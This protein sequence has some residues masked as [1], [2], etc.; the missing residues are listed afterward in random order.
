MQR[1]ISLLFAV[2]LGLFPLAQIAKGQSTDI[3]G[4]VIQ[5]RRH[6]HENPE[7]SFKE[8][9]TADYVEQKLKSFGNIETKR[10]TATSVIGILKGGKPG[11]TVAFRADMDALPI[12]EETGLSFASKVKNVSHAC[13]HD[14]HTAMLLGTAA[15]LSKQQKELPGTVYFVFQHA[16]EQDPGGAQ[17]II[18]TGALKGVDAFFGIHVIPNIP[19]GYI[20][21]LP[22]GAAS[23]NADGFNLTIH[24]K[25]SHGSMPHLGIDPI[26]VGAE[27]VNGLQT[28]VSRNVPPGEMAV[29][30]VGRFQS[31]NANNVIPETADL[32]ATV[33]TTN[34]STRTLV[35]DRIKN[36][37]QHTCEAYGARPE[38]DYVFSYSAIENNSALVN[39]ARRAA[40]K[41]V[42]EKNVIDVPRMTASEDFSAYKEVAPICFMVLGVGPGPANHSPKFNL[43][44]KALSNGVKAEV[45]IIQEYLTADK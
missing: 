45:E 34:D 27:I 24:G 10:P 14:A 11:K 41:A 36:I 6:I 9:H 7:L 25:G 40:I 21:I 31:G 17:E 16:E 35:A 4:K 8:K 28:V 33:R 38:L 18:K 1:T 43:D 13:G 19:V 42:G 37:V 44:E 23:T 2:L 32:G 26:V 30:T 15:T 12:Q 5:W 22:I 39:L 29:V 3:N 20:G